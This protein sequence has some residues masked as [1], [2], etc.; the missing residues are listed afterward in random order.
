MIGDEQRILI[1]QAE[2][3]MI[4][5][6]PVLSTD[7]ATLCGP[8]IA[9]SEDLLHKLTLRGIKRI[10]VQGTPVPTPPRIPLEIRLQALERRFSRV[11]EVPM[12][13]ALQRI[14][15]NELARTY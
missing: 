1:T 4:L 13:Q 2:P 8:G 14:I 9:V 3:G 15:A 10:T 12:M 11:T 7:G 5:A 6:K